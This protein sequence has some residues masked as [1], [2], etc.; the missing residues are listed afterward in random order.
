MP[1]DTVYRAVIAKRADVESKQ[2]RV[3]VTAWEL[4]SAEKHAML[5]QLILKENAEQYIESI[6]ETTF[7]ERLLVKHGM[8]QLKDDADFT[9]VAYTHDVA[10]HDIASEQLNHLE[11]IGA[12]QGVD[13]SVDDASD[14]AEV[15]LN[16]CLESILKEVEK[17]IQL[18][19]LKYATLCS[20]HRLHYSDIMCLFVLYQILFICIT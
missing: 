6:A 4:E 9:V 13:L 12:E 5:L 17:V 11:E 1:N 20:W 15:C 10:A 7:F 14:D 16:K 3:L 2:L 19:L 18:S 8:Q